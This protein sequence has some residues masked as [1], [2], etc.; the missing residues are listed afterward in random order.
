[1]W[2]IKPDTPF[3]KAKL[4]QPRIWGSKIKLTRYSWRGQ[5]QNKKS[6]TIN[7]KKIIKKTI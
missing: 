3:F 4:N 6:K 5:N 7:W 1:M 2:L